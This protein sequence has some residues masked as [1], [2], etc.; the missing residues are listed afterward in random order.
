[1]STTT[2]GHVYVGRDQDAWLQIGPI[3][4][5]YYGWNATGATPAFESTPQFF[6]RWGARRAGERAARRAGLQP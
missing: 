3:G 5:W 6:T 4:G 2:P 1:M